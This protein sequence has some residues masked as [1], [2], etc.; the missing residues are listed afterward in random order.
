MPVLPSSVNTGSAEF[1]ANNDAM[2]A[3]VAD[4]AIKVAETKKGGGEKY[5]QRH[6][7][8]GKLLPRDR[9]KHLLDPGSPFWSCRNWPRWIF[10]LKKCLA[11]ASSR[12]SAEL[13]VRNVL[14]W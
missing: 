3:L 1:K 13:R 12:V 7:A 10:T 11:L 8:R 14:L 9:V 6:V 5:Q 2:G 4:L